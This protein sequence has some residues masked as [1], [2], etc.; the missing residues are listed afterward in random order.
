MWAIIDHLSFNN[1]AFDG[2]LHNHQHI[3]GIVHQLYHTPLQSKIW[4]LNDRR[5][6]IVN[7]PFNNTSLWVKTESEFWPTLK[8]FDNLISSESFLDRGLGMGYSSTHSSYNLLPGWGNI[9]LYM[10]AFPF[11]PSWLIWPIFSFV[12]LTCCLNGQRE[13]SF[14]FANDREWGAVV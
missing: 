8:M 9:N 6:K 10:K 3:K 14:T 2:K 12:H 4:D 7:N 11:W 1:L 13:N 5:K